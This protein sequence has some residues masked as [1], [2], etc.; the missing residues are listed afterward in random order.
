MLSATQLGTYAKFTPK[1][2][3]TT[4]AILQYENLIV[5]IFLARSCTKSCTYL[6]SLALKM[7]EAFLARYSLEN[8]IRILQEKI[9]I[10]SLQNFNQI[11]QENYLTIFSSKTLEI[12]LYLAGKASF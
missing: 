6:A 12:F 2:E 5:S 9:K 7:T 1:Q 8:L 3:A 4:L 10:I 11:L